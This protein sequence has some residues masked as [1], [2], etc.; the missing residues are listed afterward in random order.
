MLQHALEYARTV[1]F[2]GVQLLSL[3]GHLAAACNLYELHGFR[4][5]KERKTKLYELVYYQIDW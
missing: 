4:I 5:V 1:G 3:K 2:K